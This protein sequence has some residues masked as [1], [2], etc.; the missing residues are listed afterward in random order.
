VVGR[1]SSEGA[2]DQRPGRVARREGRVI[3][4]LQRANETIVG[5]LQ[6]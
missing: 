4:I 5:P 3:R 6:K 1:V 2:P